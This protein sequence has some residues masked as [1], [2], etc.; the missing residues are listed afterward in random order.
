[1]SQS[2]KK[3]KPKTAEH[4]SGVDCPQEAEQLDEIDMLCRQ[5]EG[6]GG[7][8]GMVKEDRS[9]G[10]SEAKGPPLA[11]GKSAQRPLLSVD[12]RH[13]KAEVPEPWIDTLSC[14]G[15]LST[16]GSQPQVI[17]EPTL[18]ASK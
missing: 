4:A 16:T 17:G 8:K 14:K 10:D 5:I 15:F 2:K 18:C 13:L 6:A 7:S 3:D 12:M 1:M 9:T 11:G